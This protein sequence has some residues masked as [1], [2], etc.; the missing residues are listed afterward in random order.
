M[1]INSA[2]F[3]SLPQT[4]IAN[5]IERFYDPTKGQILINGV[6]LVEISHE[7]LHKRVRSLP[8]SRFS[9][10]IESSRLCCRSILYDLVLNFDDLF[11][12]CRSV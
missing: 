2:Y 11:I 4:T 6:P 3:L 1:R 9:N 8:N 10:S 5:L 7:H 12:N